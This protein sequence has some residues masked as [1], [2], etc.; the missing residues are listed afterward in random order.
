MDDILRFN[1]NESPLREVLM[2]MFASQ[3]VKFTY[4]E[5]MTFMKAQKRGFRVLF[6]IFDVAETLKDYF[7]D[8]KAQLDERLPSFVGH[9]T[10]DLS[11]VGIFYNSDVPTTWNLPLN[12]N[13]NVSV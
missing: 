9:K 12:E 4:D 3:F 13:E 5:L 10:T 8:L 6:A 11:Q 1:D 7:T 2:S